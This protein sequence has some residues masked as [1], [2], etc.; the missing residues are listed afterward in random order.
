MIWNNRSKNRMIMVKTSKRDDILYATLK[1]IVQHDLEN[2]SMDMIAQK[3]QVGMGTIYNYFPGKEELVN[4]LYRE[5]KR[6]MVSAV[7]KEY[8]PDAPLRE[9]FVTIWRS[10]FYF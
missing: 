3:A 2:T 8:S 9:Q 10:V 1:L 5:L 7:L 6:R 4:E